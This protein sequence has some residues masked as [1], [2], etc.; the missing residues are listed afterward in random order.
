ML[1][2]ILEMDMA[3]GTGPSGTVSGSSVSY[4]QHTVKP[5][6]GLHQLTIF[7]GLIWSI[8]TV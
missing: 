8:L 1:I 4:I 2:P 5:L 3:G 7:F 6:F